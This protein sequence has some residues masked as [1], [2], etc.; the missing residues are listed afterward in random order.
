[1]SNSIYQQKG[2]GIGLS[3]SNG[4]LINNR[5]DSMSGLQQASEMNKMR[6]VAEKVEMISR[7]INISK[8]ES[9]DNE[10]MYSGP[11]VRY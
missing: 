8:V 1:M 10:D 11:S 5:M 3:V 4:M 6:K 7:A 2:A 9:E